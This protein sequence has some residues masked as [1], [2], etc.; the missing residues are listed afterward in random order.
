MFCD[1][2]GSTALSARLD[3]EDMRDV[4]QLYQ[5][6]CA[7]MVARFDGN[8]AKY[9]GDGVLVYFG[10]PRA[11]EDEAERAVRAGLA[12]I[13]AVGTL[14]SQVQL[15]V[16]IGIATGLVVVGDLIGR[17]AAQEQA[18]VGETPNLAARLQTVA[19]PNTIIIA[20]GTHHLTGALFKCDDLGLHHIKGFAEP[21]RAWRVVAETPAGNRFDAR[22]AT[23]MT[24]LVGRERELTLL[25]DCWR[26]A[27]E[28][29]GQVVLLSGEPGIRAIA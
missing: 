1:L 10:F 12:I 16:R 6:C 29:E 22:H 20:E 24:P 17:G 15:Q 27:K 3:P 21:V 28:G 13:E 26:Q 7:E 11:H 4:I 14:K 5:E 8:V 2:V 18:V 19:E 25:T 9:M 23:G